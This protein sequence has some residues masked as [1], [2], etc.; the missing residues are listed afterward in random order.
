M[1]AE[2]KGPSLG[3]ACPLFLSRRGESLLYDLIDIRRIR[4]GMLSD[5]VLIL[6]RE[7]QEHSILESCCVA[8]DVPEALDC[9]VEVADGAERF[10]L[11]P[12]VE[13][14]EESHY[15]NR[16]RLLHGVARAMVAFFIA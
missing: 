7:K 3:L 15:R 1:S 8:V 5:G 6:L 9:E 13:P 11:L 10:G 14:W 2:G 4:H 16:S 12:R